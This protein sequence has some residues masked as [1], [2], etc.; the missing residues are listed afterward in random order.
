[1]SRSVRGQDGYDYAY[2]LHNGRTIEWPLGGIRI[3]IARAASAKSGPGTQWKKYFNGQWC[4]AWCRGKSSKI[5]WLRAS[6]RW[7]TMGRR[8]SRSTGVKGGMGLQ[9][10]EDRLHFTTVFPQPLMLAEPGDWSRKNGLELLSYP[11]SYIDAKTGLNQLWGPFGCSQYSVSQP[12]RGLRQALSRLP[13]RRH[14][15]VARC[16]GAAGRREC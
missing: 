4:R 2:C 8:P 7:S 3:S 11:S 9:A 15:L 13:S 6:L 14:L 16:G 5:G 1:V 12:R 10:S